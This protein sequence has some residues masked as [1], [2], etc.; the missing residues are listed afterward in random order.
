[1]RLTQLPNE[2]V[3]LETAVDTSA[4]GLVGYQITEDIDGVGIRLAPVLCREL[5]IDFY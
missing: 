1:M 3:R 5:V 2:W 4:D